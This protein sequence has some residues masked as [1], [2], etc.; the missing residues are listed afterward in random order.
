MKCKST[1]DDYLSVL[2]AGYIITPD[3]KCIIIPD[4]RDHADISS[5][6]IYQFLETKYVYYQ[7]TEAIQVLTKEPFSC[8]VYNGIRPDDIKQVY[9]ENFNAE[10]YGIFFLPLES[11]L[12][13]EQKIACQKLLDSNR[14]LFDNR[15]KIE[16]SYGYI[17]GKEMTRYDFENLMNTNV[18][19]IG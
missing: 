12:T 1:I 11:E 4:G 10:G 6:Y 14:S 8:V 13:K 18:Q 19:K 17:N 9:T 16:L 2:S 7:S 15:E 5:T 3:G